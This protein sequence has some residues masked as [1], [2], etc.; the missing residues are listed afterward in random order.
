[1]TY[2]EILN[3]FE[4]QDLKKEFCEKFYPLMTDSFKERLNITDKIHSP[5]S[6]IRAVLPLVINEDKKIYDRWVIILQWYMHP[7]FARPKKIIDWI[8]NKQKP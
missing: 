2:K 8:I 3:Q 6:L 4:S 1:M 5:G 7:E